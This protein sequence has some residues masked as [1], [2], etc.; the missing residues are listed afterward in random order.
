MKMRV[1]IGGSEDEMDIALELAPDGSS[2]RLIFLENIRFVKGD[3]ITVPGW[4]VRTPVERIE[5]APANT[6]PLED[7]FI[8]PRTKYDPM[9]NVSDEDVANF[10]V[11]GG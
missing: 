9:Q 2:Q 11:G 8:A 10:A 6:P 5:L 7:H 3:T 1:T 4:H